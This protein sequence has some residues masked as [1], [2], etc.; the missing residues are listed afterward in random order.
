MSI[1]E[2]LQK[3]EELHRKLSELRPLSPGEVKRL[4]EQFAIRNTYNSNAIEGSTL[5]LR[6]TALILQEGITI[7]ERPLKEHLEAIGHRDAFDFVVELS[8]QNVPLKIYDIK[9]IHSL[10][11]MNDRLNAGEYRRVP[12]MIMG[13]SHIP[14]QPYA[15]EPLMDELVFNY[16]NSPEE[17][18][19][20]LA[21][22]HLDFERIHP[23]IDG[24]GR[25]GR[26]ILN[27]ELLKAGY[28]P[29]DIKCTDKQKYYDSFEEY[30]STG[31]TDKM[32]EILIDYEL[33]ELSE[34]VKMVEQATQTEC[35]ND[36]SE[37][38]SSDFEQ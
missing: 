2:K 29:V 30:H 18:F 24:N 23:F 9:Q 36:N 7:A 33:S 6:E 38:D 34:Y 19:V 4:L 17:F 8:Q 12:V 37:E 5:T 25:T 22:L 20:R 15:I 13:A 11:L 1:D 27:L 14:P 31:S 26:L 35:P 32:R 16:N 10:V 3:V 21:K 28:H